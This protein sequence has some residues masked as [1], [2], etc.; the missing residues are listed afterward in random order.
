MS[1]DFNYFSPSYLYS[2]NDY[3]LNISM[4]LLC[5]KC[6]LEKDDDPMNDFMISPLHTP[7]EL[8]VHHPSTHLLICEKDPLHDDAIR[9]LSRML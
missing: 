9:Y 6:Y 1:L 4:I 5:A 8:L 7:S 3:L 2:M